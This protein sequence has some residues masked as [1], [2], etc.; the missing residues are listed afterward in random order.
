MLLQRLKEYGARAPSDVPARYKTAPV[1]YAIYLSG[2]GT[3]RQVVELSDGDV[4]GKKNR[5]KTLVIP[6]VARTSGSKANLLVDNAE[7]VLGLAGEP[8][9]AA[10]AA[11]RRRLF[12][13]QVRA[14]AERTGERAVEAVLRFLESFE[15]EALPLPEEFDPRANI[16]FTVA[17][18]DEDVWPTDLPAVQRYWAEEKIAA[19]AD[20]AGGDGFECLV[21]GQRGPVERTLEF[22]VRRIP[23]GQPTGTA[24]ISANKD[25]FLSYGLKQSENS[26]ICGACAEAFSKALNGLIEAPET[27]LCAGAVQYVFWTKEPKGIDWAAFFSNPDPQ[28]VRALLGS[29]HTGRVGAT[30]LDETAFYATALTASG[31]RAVVRDWLETT[32]RSAVES[33]ARYF[34][35]QELVEW[36]GGPSV[37]LSLYRI[38]NA[39]VRFHSDDDPPPMV[40]PALLRVALKGGPLPK[41]LL[42][43]AV[44]RN[45]A[46]QSVRRERAVLIKMVLKS[47]RDEE[48]ADWMV[49]LDAENQALTDEAERTA[50]LCGRLLAVI[51]AAQRAALGG[52]N[53]TVVDRFYGTASSA[54]MSVFS[55][56]LRG[57]QAHLGKL[58]RERPGTYVALDRRLQDVLAGI[59]RFPATLTLEG[60]G[61][62]A[63][64]YYHQRA[65]DRRARGQMPV[66][67]DPDEDGDEPTSAE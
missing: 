28:Q 40:A 15:V 62:F 65:D 11:E 52:V 66:V 6:N 25:A 35:L 3:F 7:Y 64:G 36:D 46:E 55:T 21:C 23:N 27:S 56:L 33:L 1:K 58:R 42:Y 43:E 51:E 2:D 22:K 60:Q 45:R 30:V 8:A 61:L 34:R 63:L 9:K 13:E 16:T 31:G 17:T 4:R 53:A 37:P 41:N 49:D 20:A 38:A 39:T 44:R 50:Y 59:R 5:G 47:W 26:P 32:V 19:A 54:P 29:P 14:C 57:T 10:R 67:P 24:L 18:A 48:G 12:T